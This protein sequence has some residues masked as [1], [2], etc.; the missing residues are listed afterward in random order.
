MRS[1]PHVGQPAPPRAAKRAP[2]IAP[3]KTISATVCVCVCVCVCSATVQLV[4]PS[5]IPSGGCARRISSPKY[6]QP[7]WRSSAGIKTV[8]PRHPMRHSR[9][10]PFFFCLQTP[11]PT[12]RRH[13]DRARLLLRDSR[14]RP[15]SHRVTCAWTT[16]AVSERQRRSAAFGTR[17]RRLAAFV[18]ALP[19]FLGLRQARW[20][21]A[22]V[23][24]LGGFQRPAPTPVI[25]SADAGHQWQLAARPV[26]QRCSPSLR[27]HPRVVTRAA[28]ALTFGIASRPVAR[29][30]ELLL[31]VCECVCV[32]VCRSQQLN[33]ADSLRA[34]AKQGPFI[35]LVTPICSC[36]RCDD[37]TVA[38]L[39][40]R[41]PLDIATR[42]AAENASRS[43]VRLDAAHRSIRAPRSRAGR[44]RGR[45]SGS[46]AQRQPCP[47]PGLA[48]STRPC[49]PSRRPAAEER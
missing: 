46:T 22:S 29:G 6:I 20:T 44:W 21:G 12:R 23:R 8:R 48:P 25:R 26:E 32:C 34:A 35:E 30:K 10:P 18:G 27:L 3:R 16:D 14:Q 42:R 9:R 43:R 38:L 39:I 19:R 17:R 41:L 2:R 49:V 4:H 40:P 33:S 37:E 13:A 28:G 45:G 7:V 1:L 11:A 31:S 24:R 15:P 47:P 5:L 36:S